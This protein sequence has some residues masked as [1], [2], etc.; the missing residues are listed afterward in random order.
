M[1]KRLDHQIE[2]LVDSSARKMLS[3]F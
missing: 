3:R 2:D 1:T